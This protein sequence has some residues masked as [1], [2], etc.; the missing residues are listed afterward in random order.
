MRGFETHR[1]RLYYVFTL[2]KFCFR[3]FLQFACDS[4][5]ILLQVQMSV[6]M[7][8][9]FF[10]LLYV[11]YVAFTLILCIHLLYSLY[12]F[13]VSG[14]RNWTLFYGMLSSATFAFLYI[15]S[16]NRIKLLHVF[17]IMCKFCTTWNGNWTYTLISVFIAL[18]CADH[19]S[20]SI[21]L[22]AVGYTWT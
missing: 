10:I 17:I 6:S 1:R 3:H 18:F 11:V 5:C 8:K 4:T 19:F 9:P 7:R 15:C 16:N 20:R 14:G 2:F 21:Y 22:Y 13:P 12:I